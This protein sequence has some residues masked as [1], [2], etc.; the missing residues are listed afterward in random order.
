MLVC[1]V[2]WLVSAACR[3]SVVEF[4]DA[5]VQRVLSLAQP[6][7]V[8]ADPTNEVADEPAAV[9]FGR[10]LFF[11]P[12]LSANGTVACATCHRPD[13]DWS[14]GQRLPTATVPDAP[15]RRHTPSLW[16]V[17]YNRWLFWDGR[18]DSLWA[19]A[20][21]PIEDVREMGGSRVA[22]ARLLALD[23]LLRRSYEEVFGPLPAVDLQAADAK[24]DLAG[25]DEESRLAWQ[26]MPAHAQETVNAVFANVGKA[27]AAFERTIV[28][29]ETAFDRFALA[30]GAHGQRQS[31]EFPIPAQRGLK[32]FIGKAGCVNCHHGPLLTDHEFHNI[33]LAGEDG[34]F[35]DP[36]RFDGIREVKDDRFNAIGPYAAKGDGRLPV[37]FLAERDSAWAEF[38]TPSLRNVA[39]TAP[40]MHDG[41][42]ETLEAV[43]AYYSSLNGATVGEADRQHLRP[44]GLLPDEQADL[45]AFLNALSDSQAPAPTP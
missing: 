31:A 24:P 41:R 13:S 17:A 45:V 21:R 1:L 34:I 5:D 7:T 22:V 29:G 2:G 11:D 35:S 26:A 6:R 19:Q 9:R 42:F 23:P 39:R 44:L 27:I 33:G 32:L 36:G 37:A 30:L 38:K 14:D 4:S 43:I 28:S 8:P 40:Y 15:V 20:L 18:A 25:Q 3:S 10:T 12:R 16:N